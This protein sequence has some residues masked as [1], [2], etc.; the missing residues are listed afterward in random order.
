M[1]IMLKKEKKD[2]FLR[3]KHYAKINNNTL[4]MYNIVF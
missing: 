4:L 1:I 3:K 2:R